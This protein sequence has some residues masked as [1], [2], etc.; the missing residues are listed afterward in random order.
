MA[1]YTPLPS[2]DSTFNAAMLPVWVKN[3]NI[4]SADSVAQG[5]VT[6]LLKIINTHIVLCVVTIP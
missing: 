5:C 3:N 1:G 4:Y 6:Y 2:P